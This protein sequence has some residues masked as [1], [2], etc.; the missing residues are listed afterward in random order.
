MTFFN[1]FGQSGQVVSSYIWIYV[2]V[3]VFFTLLTLACWWYFITYRP[4][5]LRKNSKETSEEEVP[6]V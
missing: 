2:V 3:T 6:L 1:W 4:S 5:R